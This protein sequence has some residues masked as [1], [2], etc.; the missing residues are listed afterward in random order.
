MN[1][2]ESIKEIELKTITET[3]NIVT[4]NGELTVDLNYDEVVNIL[5]NLKH[6][7]EYQDFDFYY[8]HN[9]F[10]ISKIRLKGKISFKKGQISSLVLQLDDNEIDRITSSNKKD[11][12]KIKAI[13]EETENLIQ[14]LTLTSGGKVKGRKNF[15][16]FDNANIDLR[17]PTSK[18]PFIVI[19]FDKID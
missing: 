18:W 16:K 2:V 10:R 13:R 8:T 7:G 3:G 5:G 12:D 11:T 17:K 1:L 14:Q 6:A 9:L 15:R 4:S 19:S